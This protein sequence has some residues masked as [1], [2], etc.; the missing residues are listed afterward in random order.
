[1]K[2]K[3]KLVL[4]FGV[5]VL[6]VVMLIAVVYAKTTFMVTEIAN[7]TAADNV[8][9]MTKTIDFYFQELINI[10][11][12]MIPGFKIFINETDGS[13]DQ[14][15]IQMLLS[16]ILKYKESEKL[17]EI[18][19]GVDSSGEFFTGTQGEL[20]PG[21]DPRQR[22]WYK[23]AAAKR[24]TVVT[25]PYTDVGTGKTV[26]SVA[27]PIF[28]SGN[29][30]LLGV[31]GV[32]I[33]IVNIASYIQESSVLGAG[34]GIFLAPNGMI[35][36][37]PDAS[38]IVAEN[39]SKESSKIPPT[40]AAIGR[41]MIT[42]ATGYGDYQLDGTTRRVYYGSSK[43]GYI[44]GI[45][46]PHEE[47]KQLAGSVTFTQ[48]IAGIIALIVVTVYV[49][50]MI[51]GIIKPLKAV[52]DSLE[53]MAALDLTTD[54]SSARVLERLNR[55]TELGGMA[56]SLQ[57][58]RGAF[59]E[60]LESIRSGVEQLTASSGILDEL[61][62][63]ATQEVNNSK[64]AAANVEQLTKDA[65]RS[66]E[67]TASAVDEVSNA[68]TMTATSATQGAEASST[69]S[70]LSAE[71]ADM[72]NGFVNELQ[73]VG[74]ASAENSKGMAEVGESVE[75]IGEFVAAIGR[76]ASQTNLLALN[77]AIEAA[78]AGDAGRGFAVVADEVRKLAEESNVASHHVS[79][80]M[81]KLEVGTKNAM[82]SSQDSAQVITQI[83]DRAKVTQENLRNANNHIDLVNDAVQTIA[84]A[85][86]E[87]AASSNEIAESS[88]HAKNSIGDV[89][90]EISSVARAASETQEAIQK[91]TVEAAHLSSIST[92]LEQLLSRFTIS[93]NSMSKSL[94]A[95]VVTRSSRS[96]PIIKAIQK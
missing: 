66:M 71:V 51:P 1:M 44:A 28:S 9:Y 2:I 90:R 16:E 65:L 45:V 42:G 6:V 17:M 92:D 85:A 29:E 74:N 89:A 37:H 31:L 95:G 22:G 19:L 7:T 47:L 18:Y 70:R 93:E 27:I 43:S 38:F 78:R 73:S 86:E 75:A 25:E 8:G 68:A 77:A 63:N 91:V 61:S 33:D 10:P 54:A 87:Q 67:A 79:Q 14:D 60:I 76:I 49:L 34:Y 20:P 40:L 15:S 41:R 12:S 64:S 88:G 36:V 35:L 23:D 81:E 83:I 55:K 62:Q 5:I 21:F 82:A 3:T 59:R 94:K 53:N 69:T 13:V 80:M 50:L 57:N 32:D 48:I 26:I 58:M 72:V 30:K 39:M 46:F 4:L 52:Q 96:E 56:D 24:G 84:A 11:D